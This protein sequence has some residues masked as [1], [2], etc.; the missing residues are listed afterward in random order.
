[1]STTDAFR[2]IARRT[3]L[4][5]AD[6]RAY[7]THRAQVKRCLEKD[8]DL[9]DVLPIGSYARGSAVHG[10]SD[11]DLLAVLRQREIRWGAA[12]KSSH[13][14]LTAV[15]DSLRVRFPSTRLGRDQQAIVIDFSDGRTIDVVPG[16]WAEAR[17]DGW[18]IYAIPDGDH[19]WMDTSPKRHAKYIMDADARSGGKLKHV[20]RIL[21]YWR[22]SRRNPVPISS[23]YVELLMA[24]TG[25]CPVG[26]TYAECFAAL[27]GSLSYLECEPIDDPLGISTGIEACATGAKRA[28]ALGSVAASSERAE[29]AV[30]AER[31]G[32]LREAEIGRAHV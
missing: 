17:D 22:A 8:L 10:A 20:A 31:H 7:E 21:K 32:H 14:I 27:L 16:W 18:P 28:A 15:R 11:L 1:L 5:S 4:T 29:R 6:N 26:A 9:V 13:T 30:E 24:S 23:F 3:A 2:S 12:A 25:L 19:G